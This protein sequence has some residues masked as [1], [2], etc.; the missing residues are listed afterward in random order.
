MFDAIVIG[1]GMSGAIAAKELC[2]RGLKTLV[3]ERGRK[4]EHGSSYTDWMQPWEV[5]N[6]GMIP[7][8]ELARDYKIQSQCYAVSAATKDYWVKD[9]EHPYSTPEGKP[10]SWI[11]GY[12]LGGRS[13]MWGRQSYR[14]SPMDFEAN[15]KDGHGS[16]WPIRYDDLAP[17]YDHVEK[18]IGVAGSKEGLEQLPDGEFIPP[19]ALNDAELLFKQGVEKSFPGRQVISGRVA[20]LSQAQPHHEELGRTSCQNRS[21]CERGCSYGAYHSSLSS[22]LPAAERTGNLTIVTDAIVHSIVHDPKTGRVTGVRTVD[23][24]TKAGKTYEAKMIFSCASTI[25]TTQILLNSTSDA[26]P[27]GLANSSGMV[28]RNLMDH[29]IGPSAFGLMPQAPNTY[30]HGRRPT[31]IY[32]P[33]FRN[34]NEPA[35]FLRGYGYQGGAM[36]M[37]WRAAALSQPGLGAALKERTRKLGPWMIY[38]SGF[39]EMLPNPDNRITLHPSRT[40]NWG[41]PLV[42][43]D[44]AFGANEHRMAPQI[45]A[46]ARAMIE[47]A[48]G[49]LLSSSAEPGTPGLAIHEMGTACMGKDPARSV[50][51]KFNQAHDVPNLFITDGSA[52]ASSGCQNPSLT[53]MAL[54]ARAA[55]HATEFLKEGKL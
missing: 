23:A 14:L 28:G 51:N 36:R 4:L 9:T 1:S 48:G 37:G 50:L 53:Y 30:Y 19:F 5:P 54:S 6:A 40:D 31:G 47:A 18:F 16:D 12:H 46:D 39:G 43:I 7:E 20:N 35:E 22:S 13:L 25:G 52:M 49:M 8:E 10:F 15:A 27:T 33:R 55:H 45:A 34:V 29:L 41:M 38:I 17:W 26:F 32:I 11:R 24:A 42:H 3:I 21:L 44:C 2:E